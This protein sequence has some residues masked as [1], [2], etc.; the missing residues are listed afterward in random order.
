M[1]YN[2]S[3]WNK[4]STEAARRM[5]E[6]VWAAPASALNF[7]DRTSDVGRGR[8]C[9][10]RWL[11]L[12]RENEKALSQVLPSTQLTANQTTKVVV[13]VVVRWRYRTIHFLFLFP[14]DTI[15]IESKLPHDSPIHRCY[16]DRWFTEC[17]A[18]TPS[19]LM[20]KKKGGQGDS[21]LWG[22]WKICIK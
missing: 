10:C 17:K 14:I 7:F 1:K 5:R 3:K 8:A 19:E 6:C 13:D 11:P 20:N 2:E 16:F 4:W 12:W 15:V 18:I 9:F 21:I 22:K